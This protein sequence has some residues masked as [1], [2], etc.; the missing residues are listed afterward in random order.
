MYNREKKSK[1]IKVYNVT[2]EE[3]VCSKYH[4]CH[5]LL[6]NSSIFAAYVCTHTNMYIW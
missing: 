5:S 1:Y 4:L 2:D 3:H 6:M